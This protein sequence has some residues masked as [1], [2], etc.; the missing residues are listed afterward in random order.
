MNKGFT[1]IEL[2]TLLVIMGILSGVLFLGRTKSEEALAL[3][4][5]AYQLAQDLRETEEKAMAAQEID[6]NGV[7]THNFGVN[8]NLNRSVVSYLLFADCNDDQ[9]YD[10]ES[11][12]LLKEVE[13]E[14]KV[15][16]QSVSPS[17]NVLNIVFLPPDP[18]IFIN[19]EN[20]NREG[21]ITLS[22]NSQTRQVK[23]NSAG[24]IEIE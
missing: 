10:Q 15:E 13:L 18:T 24:R 1:L 11:D 7:L 20:W 14:G 9:I 2:L 16:I 19:E 5:A 17:P 21:V 4:R 22:L 3:K 12:K 8:F 23:I 6:C